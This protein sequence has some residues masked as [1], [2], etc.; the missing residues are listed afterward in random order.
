MGQ[1]IR[2]EFDY[3]QEFVNQ[4]GN[5]D[6]QR[7]RNREDQ[8]MTEE[9]WKADG[10]AAAAVNAMK[11]QDGQMEYEF[12][13]NPAGQDKAEE[14][15]PDFSKMSK[16]EKDKY[17]AKQKEQDEINA[18][19]PV[20]VE[21]KTTVWGKRIENLREKWRS[22]TVF[23]T[24]RKKKREIEMSDNPL[25]ERVR[26]VQ[27]DVEDQLEDWK[28]V[29]ETSQ[30]PVV[31]KLREAED[32]I[33]GET[34]I[35]WAVGELQRQDP[36]FDQNLFLEDMEEYM[37]P[38]V[39]NAFLAP[40]IPMLKVCCE[41]SAARL[42]WQSNKER[43]TAGHAWD[44]RILDVDHIDMQKVI[45]VHNIPYVHLT[46]SCQQVN[47]VRDKKGEVVEGSET[48]LKRVFYQWIMRRDFE[49]PDFDWKIAEFHFHKVDFLA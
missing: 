45:V 30:H 8:D 34:D 16:A 2:D 20:M 14:E 5:K 12:D 44:P 42:I 43:V 35:G 41:G 25:I 39:I 6:R 29:Y 17:E 11:T 32:T 27:Y 26:D 13:F 38:V 9:K 22:S 46:F 7:L 40:N 31:Y 48:E 4:F 19:L 10:D 36:G 15:E 24:V 21:E 33:L 28:E 18:T 3:A 37:I 1:T 49:N 47:C 23:R